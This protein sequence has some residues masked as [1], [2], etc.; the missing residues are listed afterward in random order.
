MNIVVFGAGPEGKEVVQTPRE[1]V[2]R[3]GINGL[4]QPKNN[5]NIDSENMK[6]LGEHTP[7]HWHTNGAKTKSHNL[8]RRS[9]LGSETEGRRICV[10]NL[11]DVFI[12]WAPVEGTVEPVVPGILQDKEN[13]NLISNLCP[14]WKRDIRIHAEVL[15]HGMEKP[16]KISQR[17]GKGNW[18][19]GHKPDLGKLDSEVGQEDHLCA[20]PLLFCGWKLGLLWISLELVL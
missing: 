2:A 13:G 5:P 14:W 17:S 7:Q 3:M 19:I 9:V 15:A 20:P 6:I 1:L 11:V 12:E 8:D 10:M 4:E 16:T 18:A